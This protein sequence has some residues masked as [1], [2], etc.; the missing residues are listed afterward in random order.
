MMLYKYVQPERVDALQSGLIA[1]TPPWLFNDPFE[2]SPVFPS[3]APEAI[4]LFEAYRPRRATLTAEEKSAL[5]ARIDAIQRTHGLRRI[6]LEQAA[7]SVGV[8]SLSETRD[9]ALMWAHYT[10]QHTGFVIGFDTAHPAWV[11]SGC[12]NGPSGGP[13]EPG[14]HGRRD[15]GADLVHEE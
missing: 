15:A 5:Q 7:R 11:E 1:F 8:L 13:S 4:A 3:D 10:A 12:V 2:A 6:M 14:G 9:C